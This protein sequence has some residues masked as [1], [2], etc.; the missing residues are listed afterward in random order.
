VSRAGRITRRVFLAGAGAA[1]AGLAVGYYVYRRP[2]P[3]PLEGEAGEGE[4]VFSPFVKIPV[5]GPVTVIVP[6]A[7]MG[8]GV[9]TTLAAL[10][11][12]ELDLRLDQ[13]EVEHGPAASAYANIAVMEDGIPFPRF[14]DSTLVEMM[15]SGMGVVGKFLAMQVT[16]GS[17]S[18]VDGFERMR[19]AGAHAREALKAEA[20]RRWQVEP[21]TLRTAEGR[22]TNPASGEGFAYGELALDAANVGLAAEPVL[23][24]PAE[25]KLLG[26]PQPRVDMAA[27]V[28]GAPIF[29]V[30]VD[31]PGMVFA[32]IRMNPHF[33]GAIRSLDD[34]A[35]LALPGVEKVIRLETY[36][37][38]GFGV[39]ARSTWHAMRGADA[40]KVEWE[41]PQSGLDDAALWA[42]LENALDESGSNFRNDGDVERAFAGAPAEAMVE[43]EYRVPFLAHAA[44]E[45]MNATAHF[46][47]GRLDLWAPNQSP[48]LVRMACAR[49][50]SISQDDTRVHTT[51]LGGGFGRR[52]DVDYAVYATR[53]AMET[54][55]RPVKA[56]WTREEDTAHDM[57]RPAAIGRFRAR[58]GTDGVPQALDMKIA[59]PSIV[60]SVLPRLYPRLPAPGSDAAIVDGSY[61]QPYA[62][63]NCRVTGVVAANPGVPVGFWR[64]VGNSFNGF[65]HEGFMDEIAVAGG[66]DPVELRLRLMADHPAAIGVVEKV[67]EMADWSAPLAANRAKGFAFVTSFGSWV[68]EIVE[69]S[70]TAGRIRVEKIWVAADVGRALDPGIV[71][72]QLMSGALFGLS[73]AMFEE[74]NIEDGRTVQSNF[75]DYEPLRI[76][77]SPQVEVAILQNAPKMGGVGEIG[78]PP[79]APAL[80]NA[81]FALTGKR[82]RQL[83]L[84]R[85]VEFA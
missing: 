75:H 65:F 53:L 71:E 10:V 38:H 12:E 29:G 48:T 56:I 73:A 2:F 61:N 58:L 68:A 35:A 42:G 9:T 66:I 6:R 63:E 59:S 78:T 74:V 33:G 70:Q 62:I 43:A 47:D 7:E 34:S 30:D 57:Y 69:I 25:W 40:V 55:G 28:T 5:E 20:A 82:I 15:R 18:T 85:E 39:V 3:N 27:K 60:A 49:E 76:H 17:S 50:A 1:A 84:S 44:M 51:S 8:Q 26:K 11:A 77:Q 81:V 14:D 41:N 64:A 80:A 21:A 4:A 83:P 16:G 13:I 54:R 19:R 45:P 67:A 72:A 24:D 52:L 23:R 46:R 79:A 36:L 31:L 37:G 22:V 32:T